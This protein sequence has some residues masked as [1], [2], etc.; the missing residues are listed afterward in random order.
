MNSKAM[1]S[2]YASLRILAKMQQRDLKSL[3]LH[4]KIRRKTMGQEYKVECGLEWNA[5]S[6]Q[7]KDEFYAFLEKQKPEQNIAEIDKEKDYFVFYHYRGVSYEWLKTE[8]KRLHKKYPVAEFEMSAYVTATLD[9]MGY[10]YSTE[11]DE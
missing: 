5:N 7:A 1:D 10:T 11:D 6:A 8:L 2:I 9:D 4:D 3:D